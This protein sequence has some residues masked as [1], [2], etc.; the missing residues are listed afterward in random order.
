MPACTNPGECSHQTPG[1]LSCSDLGR[2][3]SVDPSESVP[4]WSTREPLPEQLRPGKCTQHR[5]RFRQFPCRAIWSLSSV[6]W[7]STHAESERG[8]AQCGPDTATLPTH[9]GDVCL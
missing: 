6:D 8:Q 4:L 2:E 1:H 7:E 5:A 3:Q 9:A